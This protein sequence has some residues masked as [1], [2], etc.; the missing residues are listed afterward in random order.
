MYT[1]DGEFEKAI[2]VLKEGLSK[3]DQLKPADIAKGNSR[4]VMCYVQI[5]AKD[6][7]GWR[8]KFPTL[9]QDAYNAFLETEKN[10]DE[11]KKFTKE[12]KENNSLLMLAQIM[13]AE[14][15]NAHAQGKLEQAETF[16]GQ[17]R[18]IF[19]K[20]GLKMPEVELPIN[21]TLGMI[22]L[23]K[24]DTI[25]AY[26]TFQDCYNTNKQRIP[27]LKSQLAKLPKELQP[28]AEEAFKQLTRSIYSSY[29]PLVA[30]KG[31]TEKALALLEE[32]KAELPNDT[33]LRTT[34]LNLYI[35][36]PELMSKAEAK[37][38]EAV[39]KNPNNIEIL[40]NYAKL[41]EAR[42]QEKAIELY[43]KVLEKAP[44]NLDANY[45]L[46]AAY[47]N[48]AAKE[49]EKA[50]AANTDV[51]G[52]PFKE[53]GIEYFKKALPHLEKAHKADPNDYNVI[54][55]LLQA[56]VQ[57]E[58]NDKIKEYSEK[59]KELESKRKQK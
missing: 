28:K 16:L 23:T 52:K 15:S 12:L 31:E 56:S 5:F 49:F 13:A 1:N 58:L 51:E 34:E 22:Q 6:P 24:K 38:A 11:R 30:A 2:P 35:S 43:Q 20:A 46:G 4:L 39:Q 59:K 29:I 53:K 7:D 21:L 25:A 26:N 45:N 18:I 8:T 48:L 33:L 32:A 47:N 50:N 37:F 9:P 44:D 42:D 27:Q 17:A 55:G 40:V 54:I 14:G 57:L 19:D 36:R 10:E 41:V 3:T